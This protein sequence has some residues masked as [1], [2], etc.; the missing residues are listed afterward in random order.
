MPLVDTAA[1]NAVLDSTYGDNHSTLFGSTLTIRLFDDDPRLGGSELTSDGGYAAVV[2][3]NDDSVFPPAVAG[4][5]ESALIDFGTS[6]GAWSGIATWAVVEDAGVMVDAL[7][8]D[9][10]V[11]VLEAGVTTQVALVIFHDEVV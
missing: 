4:A 3:N 7:A 6:T 5:K 8:F 2:V 10:G 9:T 11:E 1:E